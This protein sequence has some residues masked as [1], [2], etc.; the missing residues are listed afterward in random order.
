MPERFGTSSR[1]DFMKGVAATGA[2]MGM[3]GTALAAGRVIGSN[4]RINLALI[5]AGSRG[6]WITKK[7]AKIGTEDNPAQVVAVCDVYQKRVNENKALYNCDGYLD[8]REVI[9]R[10]DVDAVIIATPDHW[11]ATIALAALE[12]GKDVYVEKPM[13]HTIDEARRLVETVGRTKRVLQVGSQTTSAPQWWRA[14]QAIADGAIGQM[15]M[16]QGSYHRN[17]TEGE[18][19]WPIDPD[20]GPDGKGENYI[21]WNTWLG[22]AAKRAWDPDRYFR[23]EISLADTLEIAF[24]PARKTEIELADPL[25]IP[26]NL[27]M[28]AARLAMDAM[29]ATGRVEM[30]LDQAHPDGRRDWAADRRTRRRCCWRCRR[31]RAAALDLPK[32]CDLAAAVGQRR[33]VLSVG[34]NG[35]R[36]RA[37]IGA[38]SAARRAGAAGHS[39]GS[40]AS[41]STRPRRIAI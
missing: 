40:A 19:N 33:A 25:A 10:P 41:M 20:A 1:R 7:F 36:N 6:T 27:V 28:R 12:H 35:G 3:A 39:G 37:R 23:L 17:S 26:D 38:L 29:R 4:D 31:W 15:V 24:T 13:C 21:D 30:R 18:W 2:A 8:W 11:H 22:P 9:D 16:S 34:R 14:K 32:L 5:G